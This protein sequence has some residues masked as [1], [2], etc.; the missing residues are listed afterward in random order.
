MNHE[1]APVVNDLSSYILAG[2]VTN[3]SIGI[4]QAIEAERLGFRRIWISE[5]YNMKECGV[6]FGAI[7]ARTTRLGV[8][9]GA[10][11]ITARPPIV[12]AAIGATVHS[13]FGPRCVLGLGL[14]AV[15][16]NI[17]HGFKVA[18]YQSLIDYATII[19]SL[20]RGE[21]V[22]YEGPAGSYKGVHFPDLYDGPQPEVWHVHVGGPKACA[23]SANPA[24]DGAMV[25]FQSTP[26]A[27]HDSVIAIRKECERIGR[28][29]AT[30]RICVPVFTA[31]EFDMAEAKGT[32]ILNPTWGKGIVTFDTLKVNSV[33][34]CTQPSLFN[35]IALR[36]GWDINIRQKVMSHPIFQGMSD[37]SSADQRFRNRADL[38]DAAKL[39]PDAWVYGPCAVGSTAECVKKLEEFKAAGADEIATY[40][41][42]PAQNAN[43]IAAW[44]KRKAAP[45]N[46]KQ[47]QEN[48]PIDGKG[49][50]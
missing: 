40:V 13:A 12:T 49:G 46:A 43:V 38:M 48:G 4:E 3:A 9:T 5:R 50:L 45:A 10:M 47:P 29:P 25:G 22:N 36:N 42:A 17:P 41:S 32:S 16:F 24:F 23:V 28:D 21:V 15:E 37:T 30:L 31:P 20:Y 44:R 34:L 6:L 14:G 18:T 7:A 26:E 33:M 19:K 39:I 35:G 11:T 27:V 2:R 8:G 1:L